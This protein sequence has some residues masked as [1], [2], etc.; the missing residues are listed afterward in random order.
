MTKTTIILIIYFDY[1]A[2][3]TNYHNYRRLTEKDGM[4]T[5]FTVIYNESHITLFLS[6]MLHSAHTALYNPI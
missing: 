4:I 6:D 1:Q 2:V 3:V 5:A